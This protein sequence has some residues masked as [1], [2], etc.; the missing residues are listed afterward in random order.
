M[1]RMIRFATWPYRFAYGLALDLIWGKDE[2]GKDYVS[3][4]VRQA[5]DS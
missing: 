4:T 5:M 3:P 2:L 1:G